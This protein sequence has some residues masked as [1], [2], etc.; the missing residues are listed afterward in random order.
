MKVLVT[1]MSNFHVGKG[2]VKGVDSYVYALVKALAALGHDVHYGTLSE[3]DAHSFDH[4]FVGLASPMGWSGGY[5][6]P[7]MDFLSR[8]RVPVTLLFDDW[9]VSQTMGSFR[10]LAESPEQVERSFFDGR[11][12]IGWARENLDTVQLVAQ[13]LCES[14]LLQLTMPAFGWG[15][16]SRLLDGIYGV[17]R[18]WFL[19][20]TPY[21]PPFE[22]EHGKKERAWVHAALGVTPSKPARWLRD[23]QLSWP[24]ERYGLKGAK[25][26][27]SA[28]AQRCAETWGVI[29][30]PYDHAGSGWWR[31][32]YVYA[33]QADSIL[34][35]SHDEVACMHW[36]YKLLPRDIEERAESSLQVI[37]AEQAAW[38]RA[39]TSSR[40]EFCDRVSMMLRYA[41]PG[42]TEERA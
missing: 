38:F 42:W 17:K 31:V 18:A 3:W 37:A 34:L 14:V 8:T 4:A 5:G 6:F 2:N 30:L 26:K 28:V 41:Q 13:H 9:R 15:D 32:R 33:S 29:A 21:T 35:A 20:P 10:S 36:S 40:E 22:V 1:G 19:D 27:E 39:H 25:I 16:Y 24:V 12:G 23:Q 7:V 11:E